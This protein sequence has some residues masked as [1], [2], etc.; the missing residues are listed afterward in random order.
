MFRLFFPQ[1]KLGTHFFKKRLGYTFDNLKNRLVTL[2]TPWYV[3]RFSR[4]YVFFAD[5]LGDKNKKIR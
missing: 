5:K 1:K 4:M 2:P 3:C